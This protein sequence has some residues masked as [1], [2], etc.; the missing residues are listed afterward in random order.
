MKF[1]ISLLLVLMAWSLFAKVTL[2]DIDSLGLVHF[3]QVEL[4]EESYSL[5][6][7]NTKG[8]QLTQL[9][10]AKKVIFEQRAS[11]VTDAFIQVHF[12]VFNKSEIPFAILK[13]Q[14][15]VHGE[16]VKVVSL[17]DGKVVYHETSAWPLEI[18]LSNEGLEVTIV[19]E[20]QKST[21][22]KWVP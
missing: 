16:Q 17:K 21:T 6:V 5:L 19:D 11:P 9:Y 18:S 22:K 10:T 12:K 15:G 3:Q 14:K 20:N 7:S 13:F 1:G 8:D 4:S 2:K